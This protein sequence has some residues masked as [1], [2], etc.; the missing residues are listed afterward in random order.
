MFILQFVR[1]KA[2]TL[3]E[4]L[5]V[6]AIIAILIGLL[7]PAVQKVREAAAR[8]E[9]ANNLKQI[10]LATQNFNDTVGYLPPATGWHGTAYAANSIYGS[11]FWFL[12]PFMEQDNVY[13]SSY[14]SFSTWNWQGGSYGYRSYPAMYYAPN[15]NTPVKSLQA[16]GDPSMTYASGSGISYLANAAVLN[17]QFKIQTIQ[18][19]SSNTVL[20][21]EGYYSCYSNSG[22]V[23]WNTPTPPRF[24]YQNWYY[25]FSQ[26]YPNRFRQ[27]AYNPQDQ[28]GNP[29]NNPPT[30]GPIFS[31]PIGYGSS[32]Y[33]YGWVNG[34]FTNYPG[35][36]LSTSTTGVTFQARPPL[37]QCNPLIP[38]GFA[39]GVVQVGLGDG[40]VRTVAQGVS[41]STWIAA[42]TP[43]AGDILGPDW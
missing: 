1:K 4:L 13:Q 16:S 9:S 19:G 11:A 18:D 34:V 35:R 41:G 22:N 15:V 20:Y 7:L 31:P 36:L 39:S 12:F 32:T 29:Y 27:M 26:N 6:I 42:L 24:P 3:I 38:Q 25:T 40:S 23:T 5:V 17:G 33:Q 43:N 21:A 8:A 37:A 30:T 28:S 14:H 2:F 10:G